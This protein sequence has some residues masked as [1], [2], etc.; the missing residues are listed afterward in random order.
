MTPD[1]DDVTDGVRRI[2][3]FGLLPIP[4]P[5]SKCAFAQLNKRVCGPI[6]VICIYS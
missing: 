3:G 6:L 5:N 2:G 4:P 1:A